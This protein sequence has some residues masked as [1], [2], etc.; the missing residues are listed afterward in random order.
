MLPYAPQVYLVSESDE[1]VSWNELGW[2]PARKHYAKKGIHHV[3][4]G[5]G[6]K[7]RSV[8]AGL[9]CASCWPAGVWHNIEVLELSVIFEAKDG[10]YKG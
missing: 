7:G 8:D 5:Q 4:R 10:A 1:N 2:K 9:R 3:V 6:P